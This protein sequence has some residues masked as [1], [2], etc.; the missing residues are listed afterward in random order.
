M[1]IATEAIHS[2]ATSRE[3]EMFVKLDM[4]KTYD[5]AKWSFL[6]SILLTFRFTSYWVSWTMSCVTF[7][8]FFV[9]LNGQP[10][11]LF[12]APRGVH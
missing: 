4:A 1:V 9:L 10:S 6:R 2:M 8:S 5:R 3:R 12:G 7:V 11:Q